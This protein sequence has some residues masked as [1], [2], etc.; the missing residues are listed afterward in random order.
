MYNKECS[1]LLGLKFWDKQDK[2]LLATRLVEN[3][4]NRKMPYVA[5]KEFILREEERIIGVK[6]GQRGGKYAYHYDFQFV[7]GRYN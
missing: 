6:S 1:N 2:V 7:I 5:F 3:Q 4:E